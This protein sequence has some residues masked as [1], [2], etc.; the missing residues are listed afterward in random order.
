MRVS[1]PVSLAVQKRQLPGS[2][3]H[4]SVQLACSEISPTSPQLCGPPKR[5]LAC[6]FGFPASSHILFWLI[7]ISVSAS[8][9]VP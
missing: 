9:K 2:G 5:L 7:L 8:L 1:H 6:C 3:V 4:S